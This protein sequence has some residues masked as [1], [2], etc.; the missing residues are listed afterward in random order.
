MEARIA[1]T[2][3]PKEKSKCDIKMSSSRQNLF[4]FI[5]FWPSSAR[6]SHGLCDK[7]GGT[8][9]HS[10]S[11]QRS[12]G[13]HEEQ[14]CDL[15]AG[16][17]SQGTPFLLERGTDSLWL[18]GLQDLDAIVLKTNKMSLSLQGEQMTALV[19]NDETQ[20]F[21]RKLGTCKTCVHLWEFDRAPQ[22]LRTYVFNESRKW[23]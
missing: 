18:L 5:K 17:F 16:H 20:V 1:G 7:R 11:R 12:D 19:A 6:L 4:N 21:R 15:W 8:Y 9:R 14:H 3:A 23:P 22:Y 2:W 10:C 13:H